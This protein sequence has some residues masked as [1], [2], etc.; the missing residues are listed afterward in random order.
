LTTGGFLA[1]RWNLRRRLYCPGKLKI[2]A[3]ILESAVIE[4]IV[5]HLGLQARAPPRALACADFQQAA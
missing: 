4:R 5:T 2:T 3:A 1:S